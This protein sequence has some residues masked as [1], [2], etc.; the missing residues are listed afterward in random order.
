MNLGRL[1]LVCRHGHREP[2]SVGSRS[3][4]L[5]VCQS[6]RVWRL[7]LLVHDYGPLTLA[8]AT[9]LIP[10]T[11]PGPVFRPG[12]LESVQSIAMAQIFRAGA[13][14][15]FVGFESMHG[16]GG[17]V[18]AAL[19]R[20]A[21]MPTFWTEGKGCGNV[22]THI[23]ELRSWRNGAVCS[24]YKQ[25]KPVRA[26]ARIEFQSLKCGEEGLD[27]RQA[28]WAFQVRLISDA[29]GQK[30]P[31]TADF[32]PFSQR[33][34]KSSS[35]TGEARSWCRRRLRRKRGCTIRPG[36]WDPCSAA[37]L[38]RYWVSAKSK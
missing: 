9:A 27:S 23:E 30:G 2:C 21:Y 28:Y 17:C 20:V 24:V 12:Y 5:L 7:K 11:L 16:N 6:H 38:Q 10:A 19:G 14:P 4:L 34:M 1:R 25:C 37:A 33:K 26:W 36:M 32:F 15:K 13:M 31:G 3:R 35:R 8:S 29:Q 22:L 18:A